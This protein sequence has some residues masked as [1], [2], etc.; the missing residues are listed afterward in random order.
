M[1]RAYPSEK[2]D[3][4]TI[5]EHISSPVKNVFKPSIS[6]PLKLPSEPLLEHSEESHQIK[7]YDEPLPKNQFEKLNFPTTSCRAFNSFALE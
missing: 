3:E 4:V 1:P 6:A 7:I 2:S 5:P